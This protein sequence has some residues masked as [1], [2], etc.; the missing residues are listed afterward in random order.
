MNRL[1][2]L[3]AELDNIGGFHNL[4]LQLKIDGYEMALADLEARYATVV[5]AAGRG[6]YFIPMSQPEYKQLSDALVELAHDRS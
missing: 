4:G 3:E 5:E 2:E 6:L 1:H